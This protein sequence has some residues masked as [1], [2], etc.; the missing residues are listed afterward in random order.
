MR[1]LSS[2]P[3]G[4]IRS[5]GMTRKP[6]CPGE[7]GQE[8]NRIRNNRMLCLRVSRSQTLSALLAG[9]KVIGFNMLQI[10]WKRLARHGQIPQSYGAAVAAPLKAADRQCLAACRTLQQFSGPF[11]GCPPAIHARWCSRQRLGVSPTNFPKCNA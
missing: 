7:S 11:A 4:V 3:D 8:H 1:E 9:S 5:A 10:N 6:L 2:A